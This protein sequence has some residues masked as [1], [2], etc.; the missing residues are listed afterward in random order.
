M[1]SNKIYEQ[2][3]KKKI[4]FVIPTNQS[5]NKTMRTNNSLWWPQ[6]LH[7]VYFCSKLK[8]LSKSNFFPELH[9]YMDDSFFYCSHLIFPFSAYKYVISH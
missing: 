8:R 2:C 5:E 4:Y 6:Q 3:C 9:M 7:T 1:V